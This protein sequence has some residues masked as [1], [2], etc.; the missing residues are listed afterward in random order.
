[1]RFSTSF[2]KRPVLA[3]END[4]VVRTGTYTLYNLNYSLGVNK[5]TRLYSS[6]EC[7]IYE[8]RPAGVQ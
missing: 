8:Y 6:H 7:Y 2:R 3:V 4:A 5:W 1:M